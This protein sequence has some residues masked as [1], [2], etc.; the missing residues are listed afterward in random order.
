MEDYPDTANHWAAKEI[1][2]VTEAGWFMGDSRGFRPND[3]ITRAEAMTVVNRMVN[4]VPKTAEDLLDGMVTWDDN[5][6]GDWYYEAV[7]EATNSHNYEHGQRGDEAEETWTELIPNPDWK[8]LEKEW[9]AE[10]L[11]R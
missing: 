1:R 11:S 5:N 8:A 6:P 10:Y 3:P 2:V 9:E 4:R 7:Q